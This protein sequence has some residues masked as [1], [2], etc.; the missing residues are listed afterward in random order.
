MFDLHDQYDPFSLFFNVRLTGAGNGGNGGFG[1]G[2]GDIVES[3]PVQKMGRLRGD[4]HGKLWREVERSGE[5]WREVERSGEKW[6]EVEKW[7]SG[8]VEKWTSL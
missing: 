1:L 2:D 7:R 4:T 3:Q 5:K 8:E 6:R